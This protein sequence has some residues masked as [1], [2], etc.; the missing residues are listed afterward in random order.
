MILALT[1]YSKVGK[2]EL[3]KIIQSYERVSFADVLKTQVT[4]MLKSNDI[5]VDLWNRDKETWRWLLVGWGRMRR[6]QD[7]DYWIKQLYMQMVSNLTTQSW[8]IDDLRYENELRWVKKH[9]GLVIGLT[10]PGFGPANDEER[11][12]IKQIRIQYPDL[13]WIVNDGTARE[14]EI[15]AREIIKGFYTGRCKGT[16]FVV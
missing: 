10:R 2:T 14:L 1:G 11:E 4:Q 5:D 8:V 3:A 15:T 6:A 9:G 12:S 7:P 16:S 13:P